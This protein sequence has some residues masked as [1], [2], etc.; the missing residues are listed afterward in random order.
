MD[1]KAL[2]DEFYDG[3]AKALIDFSNTLIRETC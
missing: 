1:I 3:I 2:K